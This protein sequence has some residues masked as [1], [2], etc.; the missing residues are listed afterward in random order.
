[1]KMLGHGGR[2]WLAALVLVGAAGAGCANRM[3]DDNLRLHEQNRELQARLDAEAAR[4]ANQGETPAHSAGPTHTMEPV[5][6]APQPPPAT[7]QIARPQPV[8]PPQIEGTETTQ[9]VAAGTV[10]VRVPG[11]VL[12]DPGQATIRSGAKG[13]LDK[14]AAALKKEYPGKQIR[15]SLEA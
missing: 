1:M 12:F 5:T 14:F 15:A 13:T 6:P 10:T 11:D 4:G 2:C 9:D 7:Q 3:H 8:T